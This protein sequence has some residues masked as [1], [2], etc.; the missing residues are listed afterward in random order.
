MTHDTKRSTDVRARIAAISWI[1][2]EWA[3]HVKTWIAATDGLRR[4]GAPDGNE[5][6]FIFQTLAG[7]WPIEAERVTEYMIK[8]MREAK[9]NTNWIDQNAEWED[10]VTGFVRA[11]YEHRSFL[12]DFEPFVARLTRFGDWVTLGMNTLKLTCPASRTSTRATSCRCAR[13]SI[14]TTAG[15]STGSGTR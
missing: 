1:A 13:S 2:E 3:E 4:G 11:L 9:R 7:A 14:P 8:A 6:S 5:L 10:A 15:R 12:A